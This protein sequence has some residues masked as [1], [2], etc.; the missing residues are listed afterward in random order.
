L[1]NEKYKTTAQLLPS[2]ARFLPFLL[3]KRNGLE[4]LFFEALPLYICI[5]AAVSF[6]KNFAFKS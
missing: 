6:F 3:Q 4:V 1:H 2:Y 5:A